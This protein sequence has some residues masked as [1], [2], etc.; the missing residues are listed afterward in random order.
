[1]SRIN[2]PIL[3]VGA[4]PVGDLDGDGDVDFADMLVVIGAW[5]ECPPQ[6][7]CPADL[8]GSGD[9]GFGDVLVLIGNWT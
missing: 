6:P 1:M 4:G 8:D 2:V 7:P 3:I 9:V 5:G